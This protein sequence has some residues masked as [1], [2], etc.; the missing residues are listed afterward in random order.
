MATHTPAADVPEIIK[1]LPNGNLILPN[2]TTVE[3][4]LVFV[5][6]DGNAPG[7]EK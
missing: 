5:G 4:V 7:M 2:E 1:I 3:D 6:A